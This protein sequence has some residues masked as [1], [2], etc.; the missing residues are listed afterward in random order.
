MSQIINVHIG[1]DIGPMQVEVPVRV[2][3]KTVERSTNGALHFTPNSTKAITA[4]EM[5]WIRKHHPVFAQSIREIEV[6]A[7]RAKPVVVEQPLPLDGVSDKK[8]SEKKTAIK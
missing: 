5:A 7:K 4:D 1:G 6:K 2:D 3:G 8:K